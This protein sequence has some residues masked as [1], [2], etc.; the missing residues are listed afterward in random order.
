MIFVNYLYRFLFLSYKKSLNNGNTSGSTS[1]NASLNQYSNAIST[2]DGK[3][4]LIKSQL[5]N[6]PDNLVIDNQ[7]TN[8]S[9]LSDLV[10]KSMANGILN[11]DVGMNYVRPT[12]SSTPKGN[13]YGYSQVYTGI[14]DN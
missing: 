6:Y 14:G 4:E 12:Q 1:G 3:Y 8:D 2:A 13:I 11:I 5:G 10:D 7:T 9:T